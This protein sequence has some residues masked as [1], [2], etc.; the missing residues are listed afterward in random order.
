[1]KDFTYVDDTFFSRSI[2]IN[3]DTQLDHEILQR[4]Y[5]NFEI[6]IKKEEE[7]LNGTST[8]SATEGDSNMIQRQLN[9]FNPTGLII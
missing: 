9:P 7:K 3:S 2:D 8:S 4:C 6:N 1:M 5:G